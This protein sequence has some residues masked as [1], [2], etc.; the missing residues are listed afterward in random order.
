M[1][2]ILRVSILVFALI[3]VTGC[4]TNSGR[5][6][7]CT[8]KQTYN[9]NKFE[10]K[11]VFYYDEDDEMTKIKVDAKFTAEDKDTAKEYKEMEEEVFDDNFKGVKGISYKSKLS[12]KTVTISFSAD[13]NKLDVDDLDH[14]FDYYFSVDGDETRKET[15]EK[16]ESK[17][18]EYGFKCKKN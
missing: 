17:H 4:E 6:L 14:D 1:K 11:Y 8:K 18:D 10:H 15:K 7:T 5:T 16:M 12:G 9:D 13:L 2:R 3:L